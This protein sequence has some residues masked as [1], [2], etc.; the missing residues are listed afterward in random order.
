MKI[1]TSL[2]YAADFATTAARAQDLERGRGGHALDRRGLRLRRRQHLGYLAAKTERVELA[3]GIFNVFSRTP[4]LMAQ[5]AAGLD[6]VSGG[7]FVLGLGASGPQV[8]EGFH[9]VPYRR[10]RARIR[11]TIDICRMAWHRERLA[12]P[13]RCSPCRC[14]P[15]WARAWASRSR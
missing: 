9:G 5:T 11:E 15:S 2:D 4:A 14:R 8:V 7:R 6:A 12:Y 3:A 1:S 13:A 10:A